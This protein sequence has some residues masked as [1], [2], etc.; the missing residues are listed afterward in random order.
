MDKG[1]YE[2][3]KKMIRYVKV[4]NTEIAY[5]LMR[6]SVKNLNLR[7]SSDGAV[8]VSVPY[9]VSFKT[10]DEFVIRNAEFILKAQKKAAE[11]NKSSFDRIYFLGS[12]LE[13]K[14]IPCEKSSALL[15]DT[16][17]LLYIKE[18]EL[19]SDRAAAIQAAINHWEKEKSMELFPPVLCKA[20]KRFCELG[21][22]IPFPVLAVKSM[23]SR[24]GSCT[25]A[26]GKIC[27]NA[28]LVEK[29]VIC[30]EYVICHEL[31]H[32]LVQ[33]HS[34]DF[35]SV[36]TRVFPQHKEIR[37]LLNSSKYN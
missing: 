11:K 6:K 37:R 7:V 32:F 31:S 20:H 5:E 2:I 14:I 17:L 28:F 36:L 24:W 18:S 16:E 13:L 25:A 12:G 23:K 10:A 29:P 33:N 34:S 35:Y 21:F 30:I 4:N 15:T 1:K 3:K 26:K 8:K 22:E 19:Q 9:R 27:L